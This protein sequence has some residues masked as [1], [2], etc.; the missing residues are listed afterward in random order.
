[1][2]T[3]IIMITGGQRSGKSRMAE[4]MVQEMSATPVY[5]ATTRVWD[6]ELRR[7]VEAHRLR[8]GPEWTTYEEPLDVA[9]LPLTCDDTVLFDCVTMWATNL[10]FECGED[11][12][13]ALEHMKSQ[14]NV[15]CPKC[16]NIVFVTNEIGLGGVSENA[17]QRQFTDLQGSINQHIATLADEVYMT[18][19]G[20]AL[21]IK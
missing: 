20:I 13:K 12:G 5:V 11:A 2:S 21:R 19:S 17:M 14:L 10:F 6:N 1:M 3:K 4:R 18:V 9:S 15:L 8:R 7:R 16:R